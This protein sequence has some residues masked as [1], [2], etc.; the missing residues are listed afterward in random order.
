MKLF[1][2]QNENQEKNKFM[3]ENNC[4]FLKNLCYSNYRPPDEDEKHSLIN[5]FFD[6]TSN[7][8]I[9]ESLT[10][11]SEFYQYYESHKNENKPPTLSFHPEKIVLKDL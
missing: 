11:N 4:F 6:K 10:Q 9:L 2:N 5:N 1:E 3:L 8:Q 7:E